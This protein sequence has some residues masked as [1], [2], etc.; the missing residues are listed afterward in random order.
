MSTVVVAV[1]FVLGSCG[2]GGDDAATE[3][4]ASSADTIVATTT[5]GPPDSDDGATATTVQ[6]SEPAETAPTTEPADAAWA[7]TF[8][9]ISLSDT[10]PGPRPLLAWGAVD[11]AALYQLTVLDADGIPYW[12]WSGDTE[13]VP[14]GGMDNPDAIGA[15][16]F[17]ELT[18][19]VV[20]RAA[21]GTP[22]AMSQRGTL[23]P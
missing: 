8:A 12:S 22:L 16:V 9:E 18:W 19:T 10:E 5:S 3:T 17:E 11:G 23:E 14:M 21:D 13:A 15:W 2:S 1:A 7:D 6:P 4:S 20:A